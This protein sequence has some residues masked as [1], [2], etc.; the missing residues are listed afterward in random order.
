MAS[1][2]YDFSA[3]QEESNA[4]D[5]WRESMKQGLNFATLSYQEHHPRLQII[6]LMYVKVFFD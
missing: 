6:L 3:K 4:S 5:F 1:V 2:W